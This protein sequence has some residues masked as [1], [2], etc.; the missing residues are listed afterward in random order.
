MTEK[1]S[2]NVFIVGCDRSLG[3]LQWSC[4]N[5]STIGVVIVDIQILEVI[6]FVP[7]IATVITVYDHGRGL[8]C[9]QAPCLS[10][11]P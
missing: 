5:G 8:L 2:K 11:D 6:V 3:T 7:V 4:E 10:L 1:F 9:W